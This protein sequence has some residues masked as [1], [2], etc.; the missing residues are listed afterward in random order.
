MR[1]T[2]QP[3][4]RLLLDLPQV[5]V[6]S[7]RG[8]AVGLG[9]ARVLLLDQRLAVGTAAFDRRRL[10]ERE[11]VAARRAHPGEQPL[12]EGVGVR[13]GGGGEQQRSPPDDPADGQ[14]AHGRF[15]AWRAAG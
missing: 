12:L 15:T 3:L 10:A 14:A 6:V 4:M 1:T 5:L 7:V 9:A 11:T 2:I 13:R 8:H